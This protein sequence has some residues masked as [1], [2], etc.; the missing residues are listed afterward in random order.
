MHT[1]HQ[2][3]DRRPSALPDVAGS[4]LLSSYADK[5]LAVERLGFCQSTPSAAGCGPLVSGSNGD[6]DV[7]SPLSENSVAVSSHA[8]SAACVTQRIKVLFKSTPRTSDDVVNNVVL[9]TVAVAP[10]LQGPL[11]ATSFS[12]RLGLRGRPHDSCFRPI[13]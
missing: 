9:W 2:R 13:G 1:Q 3:V 7:E 11:M 6:I 10:I 4:R 8:D 5:R 12:Q